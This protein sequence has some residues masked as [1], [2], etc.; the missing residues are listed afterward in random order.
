MG[1]AL[2]RIW[3]NPFVRLVLVALGLA[4]AFTVLR[5]AL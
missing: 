1:E 2:S 3:A 4:L 5:A